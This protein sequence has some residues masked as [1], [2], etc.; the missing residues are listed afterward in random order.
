MQIEELIPFKSS[1]DQATIASLYFMRI[2]SNLCSSSSI[3]AVDIITCFAFSSSKKASS[4]IWVV[5]AGLNLLNLFLFL[6]PSLHYCLIFLC[7][8]HSNLRLFPLNHNWN[9]KIQNQN[10]QDTG[11]SS[12]FH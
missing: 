4:T 1:I 11:N 7:C 10:H 12:H 5:P 8:S 6:L 9:S 2:S 3:N